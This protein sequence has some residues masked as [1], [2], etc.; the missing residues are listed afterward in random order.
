MIDI[1]IFKFT[2]TSMINCVM[3]TLVLKI[4]KQVLERSI[5][6]VILSMH[7][8]MW[9]N[10]FSLENCLIF[11]YFAVYSQA[12]AATESPTSKCRART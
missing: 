9:W 4:M 7:N 2:D 12:V 3:W 8:H 10:N 5:L 1:K 11:M 6:S